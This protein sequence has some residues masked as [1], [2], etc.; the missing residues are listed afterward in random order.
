MDS[1]QRQ[2]VLILGAGISGLSLAWYLSKS[3]VPLDITIL[4]K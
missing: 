1:T 3:S 2:R 4:E